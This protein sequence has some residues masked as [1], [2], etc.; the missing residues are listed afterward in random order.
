MGYIVDKP[1]FRLPV[2][3]MHYYGASQQLRRQ[4]QDRLPNNKNELPDTDG[5]PHFPTLTLAM[6]LLVM[7][8]LTVP[9]FIFFLFTL[10]YLIFEDFQLI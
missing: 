8:L 7:F 4:P 2:N 10:L 9:F 1:L 3:E 5:L 6:F